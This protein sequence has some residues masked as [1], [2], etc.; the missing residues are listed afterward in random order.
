MDFGIFKIIDNTAF[1]QLGCWV[2]LKAAKDQINSMGGMVNTYIKEKN[3]IEFLVYVVSGST[4]SFTGHY[5]IENLDQEHIKHH[6]TL[7]DYIEW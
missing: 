6:K 7:G 4:S 3:G 5:L 1:R 2:S